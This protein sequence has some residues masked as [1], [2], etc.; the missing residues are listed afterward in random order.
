[1]GWL[2]TMAQHAKTLLLLNADHLSLDL[3]K[4]TLNTVL[5]FEEDIESVSEHLNEFTQKALDDG[6]R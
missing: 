3:V 2:H 5:K 6:R 1:M 4:D